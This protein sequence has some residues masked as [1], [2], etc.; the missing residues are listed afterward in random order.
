MAGISHFLIIEPEQ[1]K[2]QDKTLDHDD[3]V[4]ISAQQQQ[5][6]HAKDTI[7]DMLQRSF[8]ILDD[9]EPTQERKSSTVLQQ[10][11]SSVIT[12]DPLPHPPPSA[13]IQASHVPFASILSSSPPKS[14]SSGW[15]PF[16]FIESKIRPHLT[17]PPP[18]PIIQ[19][20][21][22]EVKPDNTNHLFAAGFAGSLLIS[23]FVAI[24]R[25]KLLNAFNLLLWCAG[26]VTITVVTPVFVLPHF[27]NSHKLGMFVVLVTGYLLHALAAS[28]WWL[29][30]YGAALGFSQYKEERDKVSGLFLAATD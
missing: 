12:F 13:P 16:E 21:L 4:D 27:K 7:D 8:V 14:E 28:H 1:E 9:Y 19:T 3:F 26:L 15:S 25:T 17:A 6:Q 30:L 23:F 24:W 11:S 5:Q 22:P 29:A 18:A 10:N 2:D 20:P